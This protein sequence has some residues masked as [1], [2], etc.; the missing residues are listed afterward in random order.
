MNKSTTIRLYL[1]TLTIICL[2]S[3]LSM[4]LLWKYM[5]PENNIQVSYI[6]IWVAFFLAVS[7]FLSLIIYFFKKIYYRW[8]IYLSTLNSCLRQWIF[9]TWYIIGIIIFNKIWVLN[10]TT[11]LLLLVPLMFIEVLFQAI[12]N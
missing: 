8:E 6:T 3:V 2:T 12:S 7:S 4:I 11:S 9:I 10:Y 5:N 1:L